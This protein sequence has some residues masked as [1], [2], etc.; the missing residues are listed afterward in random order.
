MKLTKVVSVIASLTTLVVALPGAQTINKPYITVLSRYTSVP[1]SLSPVCESSAISIPATTAISSESIAFS[2]LPI[3]MTTTTESESIAFSILPIYTTTDTLIAS[4]P[5]ITN[6]AMAGDANKRTQQYTSLGVTVGPDTTGP[7]GESWPPISL[8]TVTR[9][10]AS[11]YPHSVLPFSHWEVPTTTIS[12]RELEKR[13]EK[14]TQPCVTLNPGHT[15]APDSW[16]P[17][18]QSAGHDGITWHWSE[19]VSYSTNFFKTSWSFTTSSSIS[20]STATWT[21]LTKRP[22]RVDN[23][24][25]EP[26]PTL[27]NWPGQTPAPTFEFT[28][29]AQHIRPWVSYIHRVG[30]TSCKSSY[31]PLPTAADGV[32]SPPICLDESDDSLQESSTITIDKDISFKDSR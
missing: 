15:P 10:S 20:T 16:P 13:A 17:V 1:D 32:D 11:F 5:V 27:S 21:T 7:H 24:T 25:R 19:T 26:Q 4:P 22:A 9:L 8:P 2:I 6:T 28:G 14:Y 12:V 18:C 30:H 31:V 3:S 23:I 29:T